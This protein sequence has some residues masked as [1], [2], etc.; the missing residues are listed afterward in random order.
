MP[1]NSTSPG[2]PAATWRHLFTLVLCLAAGA[3]CQAQPIKC[4]DGSFPRPWFQDKDGDG[5][6]VTTTGSTLLC[7]PPAGR[8]WVDKTEGYDC[9]DWKVMY[10]D[11]DGDGHGSTKKAGCS[12]IYKNDDCDDDNKKI[13]S[14][15]VFYADTDGDSYGDPD[16]PDPPVC[17]SEPEKGKVDNKLDCNDTNKE[18]RTRGQKFYGR[19]KDRDGFGD[20]NDKKDACDEPTK[21]AGYVDNIDD[22][23]DKNKDAR[24]KFV[25]YYYKDG[26]DDK[27]G[28]NLIDDRKDVCGEDGTAP[29]YDDAK[30]AGFVID[31][32]TDC[33]DK[34]KDTH[35]ERKVYYYRDFDGDDKGSNN[36]D[37]RID[38]CERNGL[39]ATHERTNTDCNDDNIDVHVRNTKFYYSDLD[40]DGYGNPAGKLD[41]CDV[42]KGQPKCTVTD[43]TD[44]DD[45]ALTFEDADG[46][47]WGS[48]TKTNK[49]ASR[50]KPFVA[51][52]DGDTD[53]A[54]RRKPGGRPAK[55]AFMPCRL[56]P[57]PYKA[58]EADRLLTERTIPSGFTFKATPN[59]VSSS[60]QVQYQLPQPAAV[61]IGIFDLLGRE[62]GLVFE[63]RRD[64]G[65]HQLQY[66]THRLAGGVY[67]IRLQAQSGR[68]VVNKTLKLVKAN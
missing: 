13:H 67:Y 5:F 43:N 58:A 64:A 42:R 17:K 6:Y 4:P 57:P 8:G 62:V 40:G 61:R 56:P 53:D 38:A 20:P 65:V 9:D 33:N 7:Q 46:D 22:C 11:G 39:P 48:K 54:D 50:Q 25:R 35:Q 32:N 68:E 29:L 26:D 19:D 55:K 18:G 36:I 63:G 47:G 44:E 28:S 52:N 15:R 10:E 21:P 60:L 2:Q 23:N 31:N 24:K 14:P 30:P 34:N 27:F 49:K 37:D 59:P 41:Y 66:N 1:Q 51:D 12:Y 16:K 3:I 45:N